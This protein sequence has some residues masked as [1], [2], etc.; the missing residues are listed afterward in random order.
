MKLLVIDSD[1]DL[2][3]MLTSWLKT[4]GYE[5]HRAYTADRAKQE[6]L[7]Q[8][9]DLVIMD[10][11]LKDADMLAL[12]RELRTKHDALVLV[13]TDGKDVQEEVR[14]L[15]SGADDY[16]RKPF[17]PSQLLA[18]IR[19][20]SRRARSTLEKRPSSVVTVGPICI[21]SLHNEVTIYD[22]T[23]RLTPTESKLL[24]L[25]AVNANDVCT[26][27]Q[28]VTHVWGYDGDGDSSLIKAH[29]RHLR[30]KVEPDP[31]NPFFILTVP[32]VGYTLARRSAEE[33]PE[34][35]R[36]PARPLRIVSM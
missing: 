23:I 10:T 7:E 27:S 32:G 33:E 4:L 30:Q 22:K 1:R 6:W 2:I 26:A 25:L 12:C 28:I 13:V 36:E 5:V 9:P 21:N 14:C 17:F 15:E 19:A 24:H 34:E 8:K 18:R 29:I 3:E 31:G 35:I 16:L 11:A 20:V